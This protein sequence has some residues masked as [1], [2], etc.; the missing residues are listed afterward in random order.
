MRFMNR[1]YALAC[2]LLHPPANCP[3]NRGEARGERAG[4]SGERFLA[5]LDALGDFFD[6]V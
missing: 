5:V 2:Q 3:P 4:R 1:N 6:R